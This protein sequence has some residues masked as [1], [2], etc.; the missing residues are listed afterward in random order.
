MSWTFSY[1]QPA[2]ELTLAYCQEQAVKGYPLAQQND[3]I[4]EMTD[5]NLDNIHQAL[6]PVISL[7]G[8]ASYQS[9][10]TSLPIDIPGM[11]IPM[12]SK[13]QYKVYGE[14]SQG[15]TDTKIVQKKKE[16]AQSQSEIEKKKVDVEI[17]QVKD[18]VDEL[19]FGVLLIDQR[20]IQLELL[21]QDINAGMNS[22]KTA[23]ENGI[24]ISSDLNQ[25]LAENISI[26]QLITEV[27]SKRAATIAVLEAFIHESIGSSTV[28]RVPDSISI[29]T[30]INRPEVELMDLQSTHVLGEVDLIDLKNKPRLSAFLQAGLGRPALNFLENDFQPYF[31]GGVRFQWNLNGL[32][33][34]DNDKQ[35]NLLQRQSIAVQKDVFLFNTKTQINA[36]LAD[37][38]KFNQF[39]GADEEIVSLR[40]KIKETAKVQLANGVISATDYL[41]YII[42]EDKARQNLAL[43]QLELLKTQYS[44]RNKTGN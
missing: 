34:R 5:L 16:L 20:L 30:D 33:T 22:L 28:F 18:K 37:L 9:D 7:V 15:L 26:E 32:F 35:L 19:F 27:K 17:Y 4:G 39:I 36:E 14:V 40:N 29:H 44:I 3:L 42:A 12:V 41:S 23:M 24:A 11:N 21:Q 38:E 25:L 8:Q 10:V 43:H 2:S 1:G 6:R 31:L 13:D